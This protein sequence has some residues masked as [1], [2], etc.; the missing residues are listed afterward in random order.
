MRSEELAVRSCKEECRPTLCQRLLRVILGTVLVSLIGDIVILF[1]N[2]LAREI[3]RK[4]TIG[5]TEGFAFVFILSLIYALVFAG[6]PTLIMRL[7]VEFSTQKLSTRLMSATIYAF[8]LGIYLELLF[9]KEL[10]PTGSWL[11]GSIIAVMAT[12][13]ILYRHIKYCAA[14][15]IRN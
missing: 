3:I 2:G 13:Y 8:I 10:S 4:I 6:I 1:F 9:F 5:G 12:E 14:K 15:E 7:I 11:I